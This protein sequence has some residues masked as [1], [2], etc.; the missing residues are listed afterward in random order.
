[1]FTYYPQAVKVAG[2]STTDVEDEI[3]TDFCMNQNYPNPFNPS[4]TIAYQI[5]KEG[6]VTLKVYDVLGREVT[7]LVNEN[8]VVGKYSVEFSSNQL[9]SGTYFYRLTSAD[10]TEIRKMILLR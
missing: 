6:I 1:M 7:T 2:F 9:A 5:P 10:F 4:T 3:P 8:K